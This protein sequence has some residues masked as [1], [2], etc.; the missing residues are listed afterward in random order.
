MERPNS[1]VIISLDVELYWGMLDKV[2]IENARDHL[3]GVREAVPSILSLFEK[4]D[5]HATWAIVGFVFFDTRDELIAGLPDKRPE[6]INA[7]LSPY[8]HIDEIGADEKADPFHFGPSLIK[9][10]SSSPNQEIATHTFSHYYC[11]EEGQ[12]IDTFESDLEAAI[13]AA[14]KYNLILESLIFPRNQFN[15]DYMGKCR[16]KGIKAFRGNEKSWMYRAKSDQEESL[17]RRALRLMDAYMNISGHNAYSMDEIASAFPFNI[18]SSRFLRPYLKPIRA[19]EPMRLRRILSD[20]NYCAER[21]L[22]Y[23][24]WWHPHNFGKDLYENTAFLERILDHYAKLREKYKME[25]LNMRELSNRLLGAEE[26][27]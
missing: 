10:I 15:P 4:Y 16:E 9:V 13:R 23:H 5:I 18:P 21:G 27:D 20:L 11:L 19:L 22:V 8:N 24:L 7:G 2:D 14:G 12:N 3:L 26:N 17:T 6:Y 25:S 1:A